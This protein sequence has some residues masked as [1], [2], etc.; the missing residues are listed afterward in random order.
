MRF[1]FYFLSFLVWR[2][3]ELT[4]SSFSSS[5]SPNS[6]PFPPPPPP[7]SLENRFIYKTGLLSL[8]DP[9]CSRQ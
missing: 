2:E 3:E 8:W 1:L 6:H 7:Q 4:F 9:A 5:S